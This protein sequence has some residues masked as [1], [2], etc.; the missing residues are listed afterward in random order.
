M[1]HGI[2]IVFIYDGHGGHGIAIVFIYDGHGDHLCFMG[3]PEA[4][5]ATAKLFVDP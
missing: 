2:A 5:T 4:E 3:P 1:T